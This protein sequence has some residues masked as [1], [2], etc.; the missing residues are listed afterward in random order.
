MC[1]K[2]LKNTK[3]IIAAAAVIGSLFMGETGVGAA[4]ADIA[5]LEENL[6]LEELKADDTVKYMVENRDV[7][8][9]QEDEEDLEERIVTI[10]GSKFVTDTFH[11]VKTLYRT[12]GNDGSNA[13]YSCA[14]YV[15]RYYSEVY[16]VEVYNLLAGCTPIATKGTIRKVASPKEGDIV[17]TSSGSGNHWAIVKNVSDDGTV[18]LI[19]QNWKWQQDGKTVA[20]V[21]R[22]VKASACKIY[23]LKK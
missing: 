20:K 21:N 19:E 3:A 18:T 15:K 8:E 6:G 16:G 9:E 23:R 2:M 11:G 17:A 13:T 7:E 10:K 1:N 4:V 5:G 14:A 12:G 22:K